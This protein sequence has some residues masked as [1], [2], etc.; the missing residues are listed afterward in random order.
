M[1]NLFV[2]VVTACLTSACASTPPN[3]L[4]PESSERRGT[5]CVATTVECP[6]GASWHGKACVAPVEVVASAPA[7]GEP[8]QHLTVALVEAARVAA[9]CRKAG[10]PSGRGRATVTFAPKGGVTIVVL[11]APFEGTSVGSCVEAAFRGAVVPPFEGE[12]ITVHKTIFVPFQPKPKKNQPKSVIKE[13]MFA[14]R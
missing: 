6:E 3:V 1:R 4:C 11:S 12:D 9:A 2:A 13:N 10:G 14:P 8:A 5:S 7:P